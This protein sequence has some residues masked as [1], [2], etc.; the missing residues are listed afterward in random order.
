MELP[1]DEVRKMARRPLRPCCISTK[2]SIWGLGNSDFTTDDFILY[3][4]DVKKIV[5][6]L[7]TIFVRCRYCNIYHWATYFILHEHNNE[8]IVAVMFQIVS[9]ESRRIE[10]WSIV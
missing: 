5:I 7:H 8:H 4:V 6:S 1:S 2:R 3:A 10:F 9:W